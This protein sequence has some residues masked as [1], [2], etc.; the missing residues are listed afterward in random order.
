[1]LYAMRPTFMKS[2]PNALR[3]AI[4]FLKRNEN[5]YYID[6]SLNEEAIYQEEIP[7]SSYQLGLTVTWTHRK[8]C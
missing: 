7:Y 5:P 3:K 1:M 8:T 6:I 2:T 4:W